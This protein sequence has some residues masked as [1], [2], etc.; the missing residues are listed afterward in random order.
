M[1]KVLQESGLEEPID[2]GL[3]EG[4]LDEMCIFIMGTVPQVLFHV[5]N[6]THTGTLDVQ[7]SSETFGFSQECVGPASWHIDT[8]GK[9]DGIASCGLD[10]LDYLYTVEFSFGGNH[11]DGTGDIDVTL[12][13]VGGG[14][15]GTW[16]GNSTMSIQASGSW[17]NGDVLIEGSLVLEEE[18]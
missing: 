9:V 17:V 15:T 3:G 6:E 7:I 18:N 2:I 12:Q 13:E 11:N 10:V 1:V 8:T 4:S 5:E 16:T 14:V